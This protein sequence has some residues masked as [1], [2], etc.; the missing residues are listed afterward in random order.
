MT[1][2]YASTSLS[3]YPGEISL[4]LY[5]PGCN[6]YCPYCFNKD[7]YNKKPITYKQAIESIDEHLGF[8]TAVV[9]SGGEPLC[10]PDLYRIIKFC[11]VKGLK[12]KI[13]TNGFRPTGFVYN[14]KNISLNTKAIDY[15]HIS[16]KQSSQCRSKKRFIY[17]SLLCGN[18]LEY[19]FVY[20]S[21]LMSSTSLN[22]WVIY[23]NEKI[24][25]DWKENFLKWK[26]PDIFT[27]S[28]LQTGHCLDDRCNNYSVPKREE[29]LK[30][31]TL[32][33]DIPKKKLIIETKEFG[34]ENV[35][36]NV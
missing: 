3:E 21:D 32:F 33:K 23:L 13:N 35:L 17:D 26:R 5:S 7:L 4:V 27:I 19:S 16:L 2:K 34:R 9:L 29:L 31:A 18:I 1:F 15:L 20:S 30:V 6:M 28:Q 8:I 12:I 22:K 36:K 10:N 25:D 24:G 14:T 11:K